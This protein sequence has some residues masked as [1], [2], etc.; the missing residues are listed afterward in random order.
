[1]ENLCTMNQKI[2]IGPTLKRIRLSRSL[3]QVKL[4]NLSA[5]YDGQMVDSGQIS[6]IEKEKVDQTIQLK[7]LL[8]L[9]HALDIEPSEFF[10]MAEGRCEAGIRSSKQAPVLSWVQAGGWTYSP[11]DN[12]D[13][14]KY[15]DLPEKAHNRCFGLQV[16]GDSMQS[17]IGPSFPDGCCI[18]V[19]PEKVAENKSF[20]VARLA[21]SQEF[22]FK[23]LIRDGSGCYL[24]PLNKEYPIIKVEQEIE[25]VGIVIA[26]SDGYTY[27]I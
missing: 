11:T 21:N 4:M 16:E 27:E 19:D 2:P 8:R 10:L 12:F 9:C 22:T 25:I 18:I 6:D 7:T 14:D 23:Q 3:T 15:V 26:W 1:M 13:V 20:V 17:S 5:G 24:K